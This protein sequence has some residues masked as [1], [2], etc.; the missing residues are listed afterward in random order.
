MAIPDG[1]DGS[2]PRSACAWLHDLQTRSGLALASRS[3]A[4][5]LSIREGIWCSGIMFGF[6]SASS[7]I[8]GRGY[9]QNAPESAP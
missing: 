8:L 9:L 3:K 1:A 2:A 5:R 7:A 6:L 4:I